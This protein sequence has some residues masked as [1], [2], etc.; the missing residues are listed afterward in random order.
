MKKR[1]LIFFAFFIITLSV[2]SQAPDT[3]WTRAFG[4]NLSESAESVQSTLDGGF[5]IVGYKE[6]YQSDHDVWLI[7]TD[8]E[9]NEEWNNTFGDNEDDRG[10]FV[11]QTQDGGYIITGNTWSDIDNWELLLIKAD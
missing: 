4:S 6:I 10:N 7:K 8:S 2:F 3:L 11:S 5:I 9:G 1:N